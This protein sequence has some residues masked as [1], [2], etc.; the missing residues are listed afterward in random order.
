MSRHGRLTAG[1]VMVLVLAIGSWFHY[2]YTRY[3]KAYAR[4]TPGTAKAEI[5]RQFGAPVFTTN[6]S[7]E[8]RWGEQ[9]LDKNSVTCVEEFHCSSRLRIGDWVVGFDRNDTVATKY[10]LSSP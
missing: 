2:E 3:E 1:V 9:T 8:N 7:D 10:Y 4:L 6:C 5:L